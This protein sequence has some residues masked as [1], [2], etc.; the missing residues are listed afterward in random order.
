MN[1]PKE[2]IPLTAAQRKERSRANRSEEA[3]EKERET[4]RTKQLRKLWKR[5]EKG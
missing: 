5:P 1:N 2:K 4:E 3:A